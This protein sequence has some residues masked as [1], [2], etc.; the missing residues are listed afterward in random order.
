MI[1]SIKHF[2][3]MVIYEATMSNASYDETIAT[4]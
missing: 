4:P 1:F 2:P 3:L